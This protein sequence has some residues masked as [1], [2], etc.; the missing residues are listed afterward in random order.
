MSTLV[1]AEIVNAVVLA[2]VLARDLGPQRGIGKT[3]IIIPLAAAALIIPLFMQRV[4]TNGNGLALELAGAA[5]GIA[6]GLVALWQIRVYRSPQTGKPASAAGWRYALV[7]TV[8][9]GA[10][11]VFSYGASH[12]FTSQLGHWLIT[13]HIPAPALTD[14]LIFMAVA[15]LLT[16]TI[17]LAWR[18]RSAGSPRPLDPARPTPTAG[19]RS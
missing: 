1:Q 2:L 8:I 9:I 17:S 14:A 12:W 15:M 19:V 6:A 11:A 7:W 18:A 16:R 10:R 5:A 3:R 4:T 13:S